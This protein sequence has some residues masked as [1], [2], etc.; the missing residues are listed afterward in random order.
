[1]T[2][3]LIEFVCYLTGDK[4]YTI[5]SIS[6][7]QPSGP[8]RS[9]LADWGV[10]SVHAAFMATNGRGMRDTMFFKGDQYYKV[11]ERTGRVTILNFITEKN[12]SKN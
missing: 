12:I 9:L 6:R 3:L 5:N 10:D 11:N 8:A 1:M 7:T 4:Y 2:T